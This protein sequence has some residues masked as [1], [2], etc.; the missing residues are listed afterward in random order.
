[1]LF[2]VVSCLLVVVVL[3]FV[4]VVVWCYLFIV[5]GLLFDGLCGALLFVVVFCCLLFARCYC[6]CC[7]LFGVSGLSVF[8]VCCLWSLLAVRCVLFV[9]CC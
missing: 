4:V 8:V 5:R 9:V 1:M 7:S 3:W 6:W 2:D